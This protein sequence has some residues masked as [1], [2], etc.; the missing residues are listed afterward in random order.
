MLAPVSVRAALCLLIATAVTGEAG[1]LNGSKPNIVLILADDLSYRDLSIWGQDRFSTPNLDRL[2]SE[3]I[4]FTQAYAGAPECAP[5]R[6]T[7]I[8]GLHTGHAAVRRNRSAPRPRPPQRRGPDD[9][10]NPEASRLRDRLFWEVGH[11]AA[12][13]ARHSGQAGIRRG[14]RILRP[15]PRPHVLSRL[16][17][18]QWA[19]DRLRGECRLRHGPHVPGQSDTRCRAGFRR[20]LRRRGTV[21]PSRGCRQITGSL[22]GGR[23]GGRRAPVR[24]R[25]SGPAILSLLRDA[26]AARPCDCRPARVGLQP[27]RLP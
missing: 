14:V 25:Q 7:L 13:H 26:A 19:T 12:G 18:P 20:P 10:G 11:R 24:S 2:A 6:A 3:G 16:P 21:A 9:R 22:L 5:S 4:R 23:F 27:L 17:L 15:A 8:T 1:P